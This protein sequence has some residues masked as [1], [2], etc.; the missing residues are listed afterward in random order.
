MR[1]QRL[2]SDAA[3][4]ALLMGS[5]AHLALSA[6]QAAAAD[7]DAVHAAV[8][9]TGA[10]QQVKTGLSNPPYAR[11]LT[12]TAG[13]TAADIGAIQ[14]TVHGTDLAGNAISETLP[15]FT[16]D[17]A[18]TVVGNKAFATVTQVDIPAHDGTG[19]T[20]AIG[21]G[22]K[23]GLPSKLAANTVQAAYLNNAKEGTAPTVAVSATDVAANT[24]Q[25]NS[26]LDGHAV[27]VW[28]FV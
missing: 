14:V 13:G 25:L 4:A 16:V 23:L 27:D 15:A 2:A 19:A 6:A 18:G 12:A 24:V 9:D 21:F 5:L 20:T 7:T 28:Y 17:T 8:V 22:S 11:N 3:G 26:A 1:N 10:A